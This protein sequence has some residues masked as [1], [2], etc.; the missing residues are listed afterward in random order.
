MH[1]TEKKVPQMIH[2]PRSEAVSFTRRHHNAERVHTVLADLRGTKVGQ[3]NNDPYGA[4]QRAL[5]GGACTPGA[6]DTL[7]L[8]IPQ[9]AALGVV[10]TTAAATFTL[11]VPVDFVPVQLV[12]HGAAVG[13]QVTDMHT[14]LNGP[15]IAGA[16]TSPIGGDA[17]AANVP[18]PYP[19]VP[20]RVPVSQSIFLSVINPTLS[21][22][23][24]VGSIKGLRA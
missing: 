9:G 6:G 1:L 16:A 20:C 24:F 18:D 15:M 4:Y 14:A 11:V 2:T 8:G 19:L 21:S 10:A 23:T 3:A 12:L 13:L 22:I 5:K 7:Q 17:F